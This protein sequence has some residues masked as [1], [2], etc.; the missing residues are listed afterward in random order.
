MA[1]PVEEDDAAV[2]QSVLNR[3]LRVNSKGPRR[4]SLFHSHYD[5]QVTSICQQ[6]NGGAFAR[7]TAYHAARLIT[8]G[9]LFIRRATTRLRHARLATSGLRFARFR[10]F[11]RRRIRGN[12][13]VIRLC[14]IIFMAC[15]ACSRV[16][17]F[18]KF[19]CKGDAI[20]A[21]NCPAKGIFPRGIN[22]CGQFTYLVFRHATRL[23]LCNRATRGR[24][25]RWRMFRWVSSFIFFVQFVFG[26]GRVKFATSYAK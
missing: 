6:V 8:N 10:S 19:E 11:T 7:V 13:L 23:H 4:L 15:G 17:K 2:I 22:T 3:R 9:S 16:V 1:R 25:N 18:I 26:G 21:D 12:F 5:V 24:S 20:L 14:N